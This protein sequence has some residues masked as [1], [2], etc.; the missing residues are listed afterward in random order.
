[1][2]GPVNGLATDG[3]V[4]NLGLGVG[5]L[6]EEN[7]CSKTPPGRDGHH[8][9]A[10][11]AVSRPSV[12]E[13]D[14]SLPKEDPAQVSRSQLSQEEGAGDRACSLSRGAAAAESPG[15]TQGTV[16]SSA[17]FDAVLAG[18]QQWL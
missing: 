16:S 15:G 6:P 17:G 5:G 3:L 14:G 18:T 2:L 9:Q 4:S 1:M 7:R 8:L 10:Q 12:Y 13:T 11:G